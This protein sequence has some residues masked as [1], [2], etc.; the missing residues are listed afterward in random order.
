ME[1]SFMDIK[2]RINYSEGG[3]ISKRIISEGNLDVTLFCMASKTDISDH[4]A[5][6]SGFVYVI[7]GEGDFTLEGNKIKM[8]PGIIIRLKKDQVHS[9]SAEK[10]TSF[11]LCL[12]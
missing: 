8:L 4:T 6:K 1:E 5:K 12:S 9:L 2:K 10:N 11:I 3:I 7:E